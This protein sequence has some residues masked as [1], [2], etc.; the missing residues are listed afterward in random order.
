[1]DDE[2]TRLILVA[3]MDI[4]ATVHEI[5]DELFGGEDEEEEEEDDEP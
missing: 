1:M 3:L 5:R 4:K 2:A